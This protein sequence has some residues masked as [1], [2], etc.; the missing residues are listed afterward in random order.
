MAVIV[1]GGAE[2]AAARVAV[3]PALWK[4]CIH[5]ITSPQWLGVLYSGLLFAYAIGWSAH[6][7]LVYLGGHEESFGYRYFYSLR[8]LYGADQAIWLPQGQLVGVFHHAVNLM[9]TAV[10]YDPFDEAAFF[11][12]ANL[13]VY[14]AMAL[15]AGFLVVGIYLLLRPVK[16]RALALGLT[17]LFLFPLFG[18]G[19]NSI[20]QF[21]KPDYPSY[22][23]VLYVFGAV[24]A[25][26]LLT[27][28]SEVCR[29][30]YV[31]M[32]ML[33]GASVALKLT[34]I[35]LPL[36][37]LLFAFLFRRRS[38]MSVWK[39]LPSIGMA[40]IATVGITLVGQYLWSVTQLPIILGNIREFVSNASNGGMDIL[41]WL[42]TVFSQDSLTLK[43]VILF[44]ILLIF[45]VLA[46]PSSRVFKFVLAVSPGLSL[47]LYYYYVRWTTATIFEVLCFCIWVVGLIAIAGYGWSS[48]L[49][50]LSATRRAR[51]IGAA[52]GLV[53]LVWVSSIYV[54]RVEAYTHDSLPGSVD[55][56]KAWDF[57]SSV[58]GRHLFLIPGDGPH[59]P[60]T[61]DAAI[62]KGGWDG[63]DYETG[64]FA[65]PLIRKLFPRRDF[66]SVGTRRSLDLK[67]KDYDALLYFEPRDEYSTDIPVLER[68]AKAYERAP[69]QPADLTG[70]QLAEICELSRGRLLAFSR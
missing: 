58:R 70:W 31:F 5:R 67:L 49:R 25:R 13:F 50:V 37:L 30:Q 4:R 32:G 35:V 14:G 48:R 44:P 19:N 7:G 27:G 23:L 36:T 16:S 46:E 33:A 18:W 42:A 24:L 51:L 21:I 61:V 17:L 28:C 52:A 43:A 22:I 55:T 11:E 57:V 53:V 64:A 29:R 12:R 54:E 62:F 15:V 34:M 68:L 41:P 59:N 10:G 38:Q 60:Y 40:A 20:H 66:L 3:A 63:W 39:A 9:L 47:S 8:W 2:P 1:P 65:N 6:Q 45:V 56:R 26:P 69:G